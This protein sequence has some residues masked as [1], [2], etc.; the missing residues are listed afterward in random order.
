MRPCAPA[1]SSEAMLVAFFRKA[2]PHQDPKVRGQHVLRRAPR[3]LC[4]AVHCR[5][6]VLFRSPGGVPAEDVLKMGLLSTQQSGQLMS[7][8]RCTARVGGLAEALWLLA[9]C[10][11]HRSPQIR[12]SPLRRPWEKANKVRTEACKLGICRC[13]CLYTF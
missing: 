2:L 7:R 12:S 9:L 4:L 5:N 8:L 13:W 6:A 3:F 10:V 1:R 11:W